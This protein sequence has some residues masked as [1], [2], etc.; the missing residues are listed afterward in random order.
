MIPHWFGVFFPTAFPPPIFLLWLLKSEIKKWGGSIQESMTSPTKKI[1]E[2]SWIVFMSVWYEFS[3]RG[4]IRNMFGIFTELNCHHS[5]LELYYNRS[6]INSP[7]SYILHPEKGLSM[8]AAFKE[9]KILDSF[10]FSVLQT[11]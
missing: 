3:R 4:C 7:A 9:K 5:F 8:N 10:S 6:I 1:C 11:L 2:A